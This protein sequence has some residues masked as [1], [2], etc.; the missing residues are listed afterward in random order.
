MA[1]FT[2]LDTLSANAL[3]EI[4]T[5]GAAPVS[6]LSKSPRRDRAWQPIS[7]AAMCVE[8]AS[9]FLEYVD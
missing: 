1:L 3:Y 6:L 8:S 7:V 5:S 2:G 9:F 4:A